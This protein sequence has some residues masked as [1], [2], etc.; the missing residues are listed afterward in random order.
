MSKVE[1]DRI[2]LGMGN[3][4]EE[5][6]GIAE[7]AADIRE[8]GLLQPL[9]VRHIRISGGSKPHKLA[10]GRSVYDRYVLVAGHRRHAAIALIR[11]TDADAFADVPVTLFRGNEDDALFAQIAENVTRED[12]SA[13]DLINAI[14]RLADLGHSQ[15]VIAKRLSKTQAW[16][17]RL[18]A[19]RNNCA[20]PVLRA[21]RAGKVS[22]EMAGDLA[23]LDNDAQTAALDAYVASG[24]TPET[25]REARAGVR[26]AANRRVGAKDLRAHVEIAEAS[27][28]AHGP[29]IAKV[30]RWALGDGPFP[31]AGGK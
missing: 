2:E 21:V 5:L 26:K 1:F 10:D 8:R 11:E 25:K 28:S 7:L 6:R 23:K 30:L 17:S 31:L 14:K 19:V 15:G 18:L 12:L 13:S 27:R 22:L 3:C 16:V 4:R 29:V 24:A 20:E 9:V